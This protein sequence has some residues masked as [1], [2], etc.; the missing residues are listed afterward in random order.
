MLALSDL[1]KKV[2]ELCDIKIMNY[3]RFQHLEQD[4]KASRYI[5]LFM[6]LPDRHKEKLL[7]IWRKANSQLGQDLF[8]LSELDFKMNGYFVEFGATDG[9]DLS[10]TW[11]LE[12]EFGWS[13]IL[14]EPGRRWHRNL[15][16]NRSCGIETN[17][18]WRESNATLTF[19][20]TRFG[21]LSTIDSYSDSDNNSS[22]RQKGEKYTVNTI[23]L[24]DLLDKYDAPEDID[25]LSIDTEGSEFEILEGFD[26]SK[27]RFRV[28]TCEHN[29][30]PQREAIHSLLTRNGYVRKHVE[31]S[32]VDDWY[33]LT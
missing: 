25:Y 13:G 24:S 9:V 2:L 33:V 4:T 5:A 14:A 28:I 19:N 31:V 6:E 15:R 11:M 26:F 12:K 1:A 23:S 22:S 7:S 16:Q 27:R 8:V 29:F 3:S 30:T 18:V 20:E 21:E 10:N 17:C 32:S